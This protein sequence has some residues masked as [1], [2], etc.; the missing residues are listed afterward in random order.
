M[1]FPGTWVNTSE[2]LIYR[3]VPKCACSTIGQI[4][5]HADHGTFYDGDI[6]DAKDGVWKWNGNTDREHARDVIVGTDVSRTRACLRHAV[7]RNTSR[8]W[9]RLVHEG[10]RCRTARTV[11]LRKKG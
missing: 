3:V 9:T 1:E 8:K 7:N 11:F 5:Y 2:T 10:G 6:H 4:M